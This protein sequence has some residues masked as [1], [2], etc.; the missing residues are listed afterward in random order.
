MGQAQLHPVWPSPKQNCLVFVP[1]VG[2][3]DL[4]CVVGLHSGA[5]HPVLLPRSVSQEGL[6]LT[7]QHHL[8]CPVG[9]ARLPPSLRASCLAC[10]AAPLTLR[11][12]DVID[13]VSIERPSAVADVRSSD[14]LKDHVLWSRDFRVASC[15]TV[16]LWFPHLRQ[17][18]LTWLRD[19]EHWD[20]DALTFRPYFADRYEGAWVPVPW[21]P[22]RIP[23][24]VQASA[25]GQ[26]VS[27][28]VDSSDGVR[29]MSVVPRL[30]GLEWAHIL[31]TRPSAVHVLGL[32][33]SSQAEPLQLRDGDVIWDSLLYGE[34]CCWW[35]TLEDEISGI[36]AVGLL[37]GLFQHRLSTL[38]FLGLARAT[39]VLA[40]RRSSS[41]DLSR[42]RSPSPLSSGPWVGRWRPGSGA[43]FAHV[44][45]QGH[46][47]YRVLC[48]FRGWSPYYYVRPASSASEL[49]STVQEFSGTWVD[50]WW[51][52]PTRG[53]LLSL[54]LR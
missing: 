5:V 9:P 8:K 30:T 34:Q 35:S 18:V 28:L 6:R 51:V 43:P 3:A 14:M 22:G 49:V 21:A 54:C 1:Q 25:T 36:S 41:S 10:P 46:I 29:G 27:T 7:F 26:G 11:D 37:A 45:H 48:P 53:Y 52:L 4:V 20:S 12:G 33:A 32:S 44:T 42:S 15:I 39:G 2:A 50:S 31:H 17:P 24:L 23:H 40:M 19:G 38:L 47:D 16:R 13:I